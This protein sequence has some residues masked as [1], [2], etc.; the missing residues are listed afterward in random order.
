MKYVLTYYNS[1]D[2]LV[3]LQASW[4]DKFYVLYKTSERNAARL[5]WYDSEEAFQTAPSIRKTLFIEE[6]MNVKRVLPSDDEIRH[7]F[8][9]VGKS[10]GY[11]IVVHYQRHF[12]VFVPSS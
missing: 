6:I 3:G 10:A 9:D 7:K 11:K 12:I 8:G 1:T 4:L 5:D 2:V